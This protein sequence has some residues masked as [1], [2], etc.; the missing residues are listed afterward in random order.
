MQ[1]VEGVDHAFLDASF[2]DASELP[3]RDIKEIPHPLIVDT[4]ARLS[5]PW[6]SRVVLVH[7]NHSNPVYRE[8]HQ[9]AA[10]S[11]AGFS[12]GQHGTVYDI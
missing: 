11:T 2:Y 9:R 7:I 8:G 10:C 1:V 6:A 5:G 12:I 3:G 4:I